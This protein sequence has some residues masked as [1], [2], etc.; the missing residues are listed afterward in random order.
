[1]KLE[2][3]RDAMG[4]WSRQNLVTRSISSREIPGLYT[5]DSYSLADV[6][7]KLKEMTK[8]SYTHDEIFGQYCHLAE[9]IHCPV[10]M[11][12][13]YAANVFSLEEWTFSLRDFSHIGGG[14]YKGLEKLAKDTCIY[15][16]ADAYP[17]TGVVDYP[18][19][20][21]QGDELWMR[22][23][24]RFQNAMPIIKKP[25]TIVLWTNCKHPYYD[26]LVT[27][28]PKSI[29]EGRAR[30]DRAWIGDIWPQFDAIHKIE[31][32]NLKRILEFRFQNP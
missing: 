17:E 15:I 12:F 16:R 2:N 9:Y 1:M 18:C 7:I 10:E 32:E 24:F 21:D 29:A 23:F 27:E 5:C 25:G 3:Q 4:P 28:V 22:Y 19:A 11:A 8:E 30:T 13:S 31:M 6:K 26:R 14:L 20:W